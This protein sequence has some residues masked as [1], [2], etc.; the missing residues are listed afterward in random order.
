MLEPPVRFYL[1][2][3]VAVEGPAGVADQ[4][5]LA[6]RQGRRVL[7]RLAADRD[8]PVPTD[9]LADCLWPHRLPRSWEP[10]LRALVSKL[11]GAL[12]TVGIGSDPLPAEGGCYQ[13]RLPGA[14]VDLEAA[15]N[16][17]DHAEGALRAGDHDRAWSDAIVTAAITG[18][19]LLPGEDGP[20]IAAQR[21]RLTGLRLRAL[22]CLV[23]AWTACGQHR[24]AIGV[25]RE[26]VALAPFRED[27]YRR[28]MTAQIDAG[29]RAEAVRTYERCRRLLDE[30][31]GVAPSPATEAV[32]VGALRA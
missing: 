21:D 5:D 22:D 2:G 9:V 20:W 1:T 4:A 32:Y 27:G 18:R 6:G 26:A 12:A 23:V 10:S 30:E 11:R 16:H 8:R 15:A 29:D 17:L 24:L 14:W 31:L 13:L 3:R 25:A 28:L 7:V 19:P